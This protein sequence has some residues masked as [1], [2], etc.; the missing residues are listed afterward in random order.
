MMDAREW[1]RRYASKPRVFSDRPSPFVV[2][3]VSGLEPGRA[4]DLGAGEGRHAVWL[5][6]VG[7]R[8]TA[9]DQSAVGLAKA[10]EWA[11]SEGVEIETVQADVL[12]Y[13][14]PP[15]GFDLVLIAYMHPAPGERER[16]FRRAADALAGG[17][18]V[19]VVGRHLDDLGR[20]NHRGPPD[21]ERR[22][23]AERLAGPFPGI[24]VL[25]R[26]ERWRAVDDDLGPERVLDALVWGRKRP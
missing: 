22:F 20:D 7:W 4:L 11:R 19:L 1:D 10:R 6:S 26:E 8:V 25:R 5:A 16:L 3:L 12:D 21:P 14:A 2:E 15:G 18:H 23:T 24:E 9:V 13:R 17:G